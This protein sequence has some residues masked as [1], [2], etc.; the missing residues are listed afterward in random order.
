MDKNEIDLAGWTFTAMHP[1]E[2]GMCY[3]CAFYEGLD[4]LCIPSQEI[5]SCSSRWRNDGK[6]VIWVRGRAIGAFE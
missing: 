2:P 6:H 4:H 5:Q 3:G 1:Q